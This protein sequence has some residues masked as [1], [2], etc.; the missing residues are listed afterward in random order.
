M[1]SINAQALFHVADFTDH[2]NSASDDIM[3]QRICF[4]IEN[5]SNSTHPF[6]NEYVQQADAISI[7]RLKQNVKAGVNIGGAS[8][9]FVA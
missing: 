9:P 5:A 1:N 8:S 4:T 2:L 6:E 7:R 3:A